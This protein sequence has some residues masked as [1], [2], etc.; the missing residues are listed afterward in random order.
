MEVGIG[1]HGGKSGTMGEERVFVCFLL[2]VR[3]WEQSER[4]VGWVLNIKRREKVRCGGLD[5]FCFGKDLN[6]ER[7]L[8]LLCFV[9]LCCVSVST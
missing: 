1:R 9:V 3:V 7:L 8:V 6:K 5:R 4:V 2:F